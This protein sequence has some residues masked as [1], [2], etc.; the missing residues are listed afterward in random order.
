MIDIFYLNKSNLASFF[1]IF[2]IYSIHLI[3]LGSRKSK[4]E[5][6]ENINEPYILRDF[7]GQVV[8]FHPIQY[9]PATKV[10]R[11]YTNIEIQ[12]YSENDNSVN[13]FIRDKQPDTLDN[14]FKN[15]YE[16][17]FLNFDTSTEDVSMVH[18]LTRMLEPYYY[19]IAK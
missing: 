6:N 11:V 4:N 10:L 17:H 1:I 16:S 2:F 12:V 7:R 19:G 18:K 15:I 3:H 13:P 14:E 9:N 5:I 8:E